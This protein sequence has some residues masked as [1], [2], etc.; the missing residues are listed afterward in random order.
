M[1]RE[2]SPCGRHGALHQHGNS[3]R[4]VAETIC[5]QEQ[6][7]TQGL[8]CRLRSGAS[9]GSRTSDQEVMIPLQPM[10][11]AGVD[12]CAAGSSVASVPPRQE[13]HGSHYELGLDR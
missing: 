11:S 12:T 1:T 2:A 3:E 6:V 7:G 5:R 10:I 13:R 4:C 9:V 8:L